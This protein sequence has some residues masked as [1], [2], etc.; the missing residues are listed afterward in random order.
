MKWLDIYET[1]V[2]EYIATVPFEERVRGNGT[3]TLPR[4]P[5][6][7]AF[8]RLEKRGLIFLAHEAESFQTYRLTPIAILIRSALQSRGA[9]L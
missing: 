1:R 4:S 6:W 5:E 9:S 8:N 3:F 2:M 7:F